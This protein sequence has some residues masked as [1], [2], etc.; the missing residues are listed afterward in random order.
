M[1]TIHSISLQN[2][3][4]KGANFASISFN[5]SYSGNM[6]VQYAKFDE[7]TGITTTTYGNL[8]RNVEASSSVI[9]NGS[10]SKKIN[11][12]LNLTLRYNKIENKVI[13]TQQ[14][15]G[16]SGLAAGFF[17]YRITEL[18]TLSGSGGINRQTYNLVNSISSNPFY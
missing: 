6:I 4:I 10:L 17:A 18:F 11:S 1:Q 16:F 8:G 13:T 5:A 15:K 3:F 7:Q 14:A 12:G 2:R 9:L